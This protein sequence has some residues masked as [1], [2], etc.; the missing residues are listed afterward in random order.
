M[1]CVNNGAASV[2]ANIQRLFLRKWKEFVPS[3]CVGSPT[4]RE[5][6]LP[7]LTRGL[8]THGSAK[9]LS[10][11]IGHF[12]EKRAAIAAKTGLELTTKRIEPM[13]IQIIVVSDV[14]RRARIRCPAK[15]ELTFDVRRNRIEVDATT[16]KNKTSELISWFHRN[17][18]FVES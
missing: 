12:D 15:K 10:E 8:L 11:E 5:G 3:Q 2:V 9:T 7:L 18:I 16:R 13:T 14:E 1:L 17:Y 4:V 6:Y